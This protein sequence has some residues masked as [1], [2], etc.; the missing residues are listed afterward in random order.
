MGQP[1]QRQ[2][3]AIFAIRDAK[4]FCLIYLR[5]HDPAIAHDCRDSPPGKRY[6]NILVP[7]EPLAFDREEQLARANRSRINRIPQCLRRRIKFTIGVNPIGNLSQRPAS[8]DLLQNPGSH[9]HIIEWNR[10]IAQ[11]LHLFMPLTRQQD[12]VAGTRRT[13]RNLNRSRAIF[14]YD[15]GCTSHIH[16]CQSLFNNRHRFFTARVIAGQ[17]HQIAA[18]PSR[19]PHFLPFRPVP[20]TAAPKKRNHTAPLLFH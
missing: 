1:L 15:A 17:H 2:Q 20:V 8:S 11:N 5:R 4:K 9:S 19:T 14:F 7:I 18:L 13:N 16:P 6:L 10:T 12:N 3:D